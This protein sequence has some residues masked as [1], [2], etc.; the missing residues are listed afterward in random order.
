[1]DTRNLSVVAYAAGWTMWL[2]KDT[3]LQLEKILAQKI[4]NK[5]YSLCSVGDTVLIVARDGTADT[6]IV[7]VEE[8]R[9][10]L[11]TKNV[12]KFEE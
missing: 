7:A 2:Y 8:N 9:V 5:L 3:T 1:M 11:K 6:I 12:V 10:V 4:F